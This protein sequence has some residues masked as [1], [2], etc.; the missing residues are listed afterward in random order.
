[1]YINLLF[2]QTSALQP[3]TEEIKVTCAMIAAEK[4]LISM[5]IFTMVA[6]ARRFCS[7]SSFA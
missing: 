6:S 7:R 3:F 2:C 1:M 5:A 4:D